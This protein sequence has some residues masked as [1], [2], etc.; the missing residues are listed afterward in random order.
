MNT[1]PAA[2]PTRPKP[3][4]SPEVRNNTTRRELNDTTKQ[5]YQNARTPG[6][7]GT[8]RARP[9]WNVDI[10]NNYKVTLSEI[11]YDPNTKQYSRTIGNQNGQR[12]VVSGNSAREISLRARGANGQEEAGGLR[13]DRAGWLNRDFSVTQHNDQN[14]AVMTQRTRRSGW[15]NSATGAVLHLATGNIQGFGQNLGAVFSGERNRVEVDHHGSD[16]GDGDQTIHLNAENEP[17]RVYSGNTRSWNWMLNRGHNLNASRSDTANY[18]I[19]RID[20]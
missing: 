3:R 2:T 11:T 9:R 4:I 5:Q 20:G 17:L 1:T 15:F 16:V 14:Q 13:I 10:G 8:G 19:T 12:V 18:N 7:D 6:T